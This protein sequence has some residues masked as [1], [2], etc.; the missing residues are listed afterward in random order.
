MTCITDQGL[1]LL[2][3]E[4]EFKSWLQKIKE[5]DPSKSDE[6]VERTLV[7]FMECNNGNYPGTTPF[8]QESI[9]FDQLTD[10]Y[11][12]DEVSAMEVYTLLFDEDFIKEFGNWCGMP[13]DTEGLTEEQI[14][15][16]EEEDQA[17]LFRA[18][19]N[20]IGEP[21]LLFVNSVNHQSSHAASAATTKKDSNLPFKI[22][23]ENGEARAEVGYN[24]PVQSGSITFIAAKNVTMAV[25]HDEEIQINNDEV[26]KAYDFTSENKGFTDK[27]LSAFLTQSSKDLYYISKQISKVNAKLRYNADAIHN[28]EEAIAFIRSEYPNLIFDDDNSSPFG[29]IQL[30]TTVSKSKTTWQ[31]ISPEGIFC[32]YNRYNING[33]TMTE[34]TQTDVDRLAN[35]FFIGNKNKVFDKIRGYIIDNIDVVKPDSSLVSPIVDYYGDHFV[36]K[37]ASNRTQHNIK[38]EFGLTY[39]VN[40]FKKNPDQFTKYLN[41]AKQFPEIAQN[42]AGAETIKD[43]NMVG[44]LIGSILSGE[45]IDGN[46]Y[47]AHA[48]DQTA[49]DQAI[50]VSRHQTF[51]REII[52]Q[53]WKD[54]TYDISSIKMPFLSKCLRDL[55]DK[56][57]SINFSDITDNVSKNRNISKLNEDNIVHS[58]CD[59]I[60][61]VKA[62]YT[63]RRNDSGTKKAYDATEYTKIA[64][65]YEQLNALNKD[66]KE[67]LISKSGRT[68]TVNGES[69]ESL[70]SK[71]FTCIDTIVSI[72][73]DDISKLEDFIWH[74]PEMYTSEYYSSLLYFDRS[75]IKM[76]KAQKEI[77]EE[78]FNLDSKDSDLIQKALYDIFSQRQ[79][80]MFDEL[81]SRYYKNYAKLSSLRTIHDKRGSLESIITTMIEDAISHIVDDWCNKNLKCLTEQE[82]REYRE[83]LKLDL[84]GHIN[85]GMALDTAIGGA[86]SSG[87]NIINVLYRIIQTQGKRSNLLIKQKG[88]ALVKKFKSTFD[89]HSPFN[90]CKVF[91]E[92][93]DGQTTGYFTRDVN[94]GQY[95][96]AKVTKQRELLNQLP[97]DENGQP[98]Y[99]TI[100]ES[101]STKTKLFIEWGVGSERYQNKFLDDMDRWIEQNANRRYN[102]QY[103]IDRR[104]I[105]GKDRIINGAKISVGNEA[106]NRQNTIRRQIDGIKNRYR[107]K[108]TG[109]FLPF[110]VPPVQ[111]KILESLEYQLQ[112]LSSPYEKYTYSDGTSGIREKTGL[113]L[114]IALNIR[115]WNQYIQD[116]RN[117]TQDTERYNEVE[118][119]IKSRIGHGITKEDYDAFV[120]YYH[121]TQ[122]K[123]EYYDTLE[124]MYKGGYG[125]YQDEIDDIRFRRRSILARVKHG[126]KGLLQYPDLDELTESEWQELKRLDLRESKIKS[127]LPPRFNTVDSI[128]ASLPVENESTGE[129]FLEEHK[130]AGKLHEYTD[131]DGVTHILSVYFISIPADYEAMTEDVLVD[132]FSIESS[133]YM[134]N[135]GFDPKNSSYEQPRAYEYD[136]STRKANKNKKLYKNDAYEE[137]VKNPK[138]FEL[139]RQIKCLVML[140][141]RLIINFLKYTREK[142]LFIQEEGAM[143]STHLSIN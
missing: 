138:L 116:K 14:K 37:P 16:K 90:Q 83:N 75:V 120:S 130:K 127:K 46:Y 2:R 125:E 35:L 33:T 45:I 7:A 102:A 29:S 94:Y 30:M 117:Y 122:A 52:E 111:K 143:L 133:E 40:M 11:D 34:Q 63:Y 44:N 15:E 135:T 123:Q 65:V 82:E 128:T 97:K 118:Q 107:D 81:R 73:D 72:M 32:A 17:K 71:Y 124:E 74:T 41:W 101:K 93:I 70:I 58:F 36:L 77:T 39:A 115:E 91:C 112:S 28:R 49:I 31:I 104:R 126:K 68:E 76:Y 96:R 137:I 38:T 8:G 55:S 79:V 18:V 139:M 6:E 64:A 57:K 141:Y 106:A 103:Y 86:S 134:D 3:E 88:D 84:E 48:F 132:E 53:L 26:Y 60:D 1:A 19:R 142:L 99:Y 21:A 10:I 42:S 47:T 20:K 85:A 98:L 78:L 43:V 66:I 92:M 27:R 5:Q 140:P 23:I 100:D 121:K 24:R 13:V 87:H 110:K 114:A 56:Y 62:A 136:F 129:T 51:V 105:L 131:N 25:A 67:Y 9:V 12:G 95:Y 108:E 59:T 109:V 54:M 50:F 69:L 22:V 4:D 113:D 80:G 89:N 61:K 119:E